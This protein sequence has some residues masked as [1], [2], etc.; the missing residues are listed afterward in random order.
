MRSITSADNARFK[1]WL[2]LADSARAVRS[3]RQTLAEGLHLAESIH[4]SGHAVEAVLVR[5]GTAAG[6]AIAWAEQFSAAGAQA[7]ELS[8]TLF[9]RLAPVERGAGLLLQIPVP[10][11]GSL[12]SADTLMLDGV[13]DPGNAGALLRVA[14]AAG[15]RNVLATPGT[16]AL[17]AP[18]VL[19]G[20][21]GAHFRLHIMEESAIPDVRSMLPIPWVGAVAHGGAS[22]WR[23][24][25][26]V[27]A[28]GFIVG[29]EGSG[30][31]AAATAIC[32]Q[33]LTIPL[34]GAVESLN[35]TAAAA[36]LLFERCRQAETSRAR[37]LLSA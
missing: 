10:D 5:R 28:L 24:T 4:A 14:A 16:A 26:G 12:Q 34:A 31:S 33:T 6:P 11:A 27:P 30:L 20:A 25:L 22:L 18:K 7:F 19:R 8:A 9:D 1:R 15:I 35:V 36:V 32:D 21:Q 37:L 29:S 2:R 23:A 3:Q 17:W 13:Q